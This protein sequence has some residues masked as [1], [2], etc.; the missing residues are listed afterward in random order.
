[1][2]TSELSQK[3]VARRGKRC[4]PVADF[5]RT[6]LQ[7][8]AQNGEPRHS[9]LR[10]AILHALAVGYWGPG[11]KIPAEIE[12]SHAVSLSLGTVQKALTKLAN[13]HVLVRKHGHGTF[14]SGD[15]PQSSQLLHF[16]FIADDGATLMPIYAE[17]LDRIIIHGKGPWSE[18]LKSASSFIR[19]RRMINIADEF[20]CLSEFYI[21]AARFKQI[22]DM[23]F[24]ELHRVVIRNILAK[25]FNAPTLAVSQRI[26]S[27]EFPNTVRS[28]LK[29]PR[30]RG[31]GL[32]LEILSYTHYREP[33][34]F[35][36]IYVPSGARR[37]DVSSIVV[38][39]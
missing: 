22:L 33:V 25:H 28:L 2:A 17:A 37:L 14:V 23:P 3:S 10:A 19:I 36:K 8:A 34:S 18:F 35:Q 16:R 39:K 5:L 21:D 4:L 32:V 12:L 20:N 13:E 27:T 30:K 9:S 29:L 31:F 15:R 1:M 24:R 11:D 38:V 26:Y 7:T 6:A